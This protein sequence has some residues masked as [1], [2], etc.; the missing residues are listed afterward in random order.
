LQLG[1][2]REVLVVQF[3]WFAISSSGERLLW[4]IKNVILLIDITTFWRKIIVLWYES[5]LV[6]SSDWPLLYIN[7]ELVVSLL[8]K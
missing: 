7:L 3:T 5:P 6:I 1:S 4:L 2:S 8:V